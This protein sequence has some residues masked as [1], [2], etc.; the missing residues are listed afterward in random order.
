MDL[1]TCSSFKGRVLWPADNVFDAS[2]I[3]GVGAALV[4][5]RCFVLGG[6]HRRH[7][8]LYIYDIKNN[9]WSFSEIRNNLL[10]YGQVK[11]VFTVADTLYAFVWSHDI[12]ERCHKLSMDVLELKEWQILTNSG[13]APTISSGFSGCFVEPRGEAIITC[14][15]SDENST[16]VLA[17]RIEEKRWYSPKVKGESP[18]LQRDHATCTTRLKVFALGGRVVNYLSLYVLDV[19][20]VPYIWSKPVGLDYT[21]KSRFCFEV[22]CTV[23]RIFV[24]G[25]FGGES[26]FDVFSL[27]EH[28]WLPRVP[29]DTDH[30]TGTSSNAMVQTAEKLMVFGGFFL[31]INTPLEITAA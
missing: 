28:R 24:Y 26:A 27:R 3:Y 16:T 6:F 30:P 12:P 21:P 17:Y 22:A 31:T 10:V 19:S 4:G 20:S 1:T 11:V 23:N 2:K 9:R 5:H 8:K 18:R 7:D 25:G 15:L 14:P 13:D 29:F